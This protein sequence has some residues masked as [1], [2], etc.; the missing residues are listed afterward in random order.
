MTM[1]WLVASAI[2]API[3]AC[4]VLY[5]TRAERAA[6]DAMAEVARMNAQTAAEQRA[7]ARMQRRRDRLVARARAG[8]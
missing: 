2:I 6:A 1:F 3:V 5:R 8:R 7:E 4:A